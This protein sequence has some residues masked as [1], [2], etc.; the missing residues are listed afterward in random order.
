MAWGWPYHLVHMIIV[1][2][3]ASYHDAY[4]RFQISSRRVYGFKYSYNIYLFTMYLIFTSKRSSNHSITGNLDTSTIVK[5]ISKFT[6]LNVVL[7]VF[8]VANIQFICFVTK[9]LS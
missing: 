1:T 2:L 5:L 4:L 8:R 7:L 9:P 6:A 3:V